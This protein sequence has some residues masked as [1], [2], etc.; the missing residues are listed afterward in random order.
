MSSNKKVPPRTILSTFAGGRV[1]SP[2]ADGDF[3]WT[4]TSP[5]AR[6]AWKP[7]GSDSFTV[8]TLDH[9]IKAAPKVV[10]GADRQR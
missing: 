6:V 4:F 5:K 9:I 10:L 2:G 3:K 8:D 1:S 7:E